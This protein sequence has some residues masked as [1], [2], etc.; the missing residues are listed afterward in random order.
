[1]LPSAKKFLEITSNT[2]PD[3]A[4]ILGSGLTNFFEEKDSCLLFVMNDM[5]FFCASVLPDVCI[6]K[7]PIVDPKLITFSQKKRHYML[8][9]A[10]RG[11]I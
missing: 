3:I 4:V 11:D 8:F 1:M 6:S 5:P 10:P 9:C 2:S 7:S